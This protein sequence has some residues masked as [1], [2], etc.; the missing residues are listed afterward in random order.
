VVTQTLIAYC[1]LIHV[2]AAA[3][4]SSQYG[5]KAKIIRLLRIADRLV[6]MARSM[7]RDFRRLDRLRSTRVE[8]KQKRKAGGN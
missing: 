1:R 2:Q 6:R 3:E 4:A 8:E 5:M 7:R